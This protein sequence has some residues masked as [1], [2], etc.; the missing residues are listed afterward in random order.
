[1]LSKLHILAE[2]ENIPVSFSLLPPQISSRHF[3]V[4]F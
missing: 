3:I 2:I 1:M 4:S